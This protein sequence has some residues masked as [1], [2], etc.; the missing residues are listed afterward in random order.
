MVKSFKEKEIDV[1]MKIF[2]SIAGD[3]GNIKGRY[4]VYARTFL[5]MLEVYNDLLASRFPFPGEDLLYRM[6]H[7]YMHGIFS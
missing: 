4:T 7:Q 5:G 3:H 6:L 1:I 2:K